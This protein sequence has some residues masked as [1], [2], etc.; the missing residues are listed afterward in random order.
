[1]TI[2]G[3]LLHWTQANSFELV[4]RQNHGHPQGGSKTGICPSQLEIGTKNQNFLENLTSAAQLRLIDLFIALTV[5]F[6]ISSSH[7]TRIRFIVLVS[8]SGELAVHSF[9]LLFLQR[10]AG[11]LAIGC[12]YCWSL[13]CN[14][15]MATN[16]LMFTSSYDIRR[17]AACDSWKQTSW[18]VIL[19]GSDCDCW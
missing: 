15:N 8:C 1:M 12:F 18:Q 9:P 2:V 17:F 19:R 4:V 5:Y 14:N 11:K 3:A 16:L 13:L 10:Q 7:C 6:P